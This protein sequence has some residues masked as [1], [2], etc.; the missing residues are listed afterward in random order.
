MLK[1]IYD[2]AVKNN[3][4]KDIRYTDKWIRYHICIDTEG[5]VIGLEET[6]KQIKT[7]CPTYLK[8]I[9][10]GDTSNFLVDKA[11]VVLDKENKKYKSFYNGIE[12]C[13]KTCPELLSIK[14]FLDK[15]HEEFEYVENIT[16]KNLKTSTALISF[17]VNGEYVEKLDSWK[18]YFEKK[19][20]LLCEEKEQEG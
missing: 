18:E 2:Y 12:E 15:E 19:Y 5:N 10:Q 4:Y 11:C 6:S 16:N 14:K 9:L 8:R 20:K 17:K 7:T 1:H 13:S 3:L